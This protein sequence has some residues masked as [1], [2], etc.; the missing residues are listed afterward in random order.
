MLLARDS[1]T[2]LHLPMIAGIVVF[3]IGVKRTLLHVE[4]HLQIV[5]A[6]ALFGGAAVYLLALSAFKRR[7]VGSFNWQRIAAAVIL[8]CLVPVALR[9][10]AL[11][12]LAL[13]SLTLCGLIAFE[14][15]RFSAARTH[16]TRRLRHVGPT[17]NT[18]ARCQ[19]AIPPCSSQRSSMPSRSRR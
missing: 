14:Y 9:V 17:L 6:V 7:N 2:Y 19:S 3:A 10:P 12:S 1:Y 13:V 4:G 11:V 16:P 8:G 18:F 15:V 5:V